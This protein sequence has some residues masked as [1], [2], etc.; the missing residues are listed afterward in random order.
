MHRCTFSVAGVCLTEKD[1]F[2]RSG[3]GQFERKLT[4]IKQGDDAREAP[5]GGGSQPAENPGLVPKGRTTITQRFDVGLE[6]RIVFSPEG[7]AGSPNDCRWPH[8]AAV[9]NSPDS[10]IQFPPT[11]QPNEYDPETK[12][13]AF[14]I[15]IC[16][17]IARGRNHLSMARGTCARSSRD[18]ES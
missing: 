8:M 2:P 13:A 11:V 4:Q 5:F 9:H 18:F 15:S 12:S 7:T 17:R 10:N 3:H 16:C 6:S 14:P 1:R